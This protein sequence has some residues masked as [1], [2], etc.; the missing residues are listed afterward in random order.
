MI[1]YKWMFDNND[2]VERVLGFVFTDS[3]APR[4]FTRNR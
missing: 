3:A 2:V 4:F 1:Y